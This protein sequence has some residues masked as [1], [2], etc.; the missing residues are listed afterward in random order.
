MIPAG[1]LARAEEPA[2][3]AVFLGSNQRSYVTG[4]DL[5]VD[6]NVCQGVKPKIRSR[7]EPFRD[8]DSS[9]K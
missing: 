5:M 9:T 3:A 6:G 8:H 2:S 4:S 7:F 1:S